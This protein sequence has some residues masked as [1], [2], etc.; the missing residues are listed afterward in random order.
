MNSRDATPVSRDPNG[1]VTV[2][3]IDDE[4]GIRDVFRDALT[5]FGYRVDATPSGFHALSMFA[6][7]RHRVVLTDL[8]MPE[9][10]GWEVIERLRGI[11]PKVAI[12][13]V[14][15]HALQTDIDRAHAEHIVL[16]QKPVMIRVLAQLIATVLGLDAP[17]TR[18][19]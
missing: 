9:M 18:P 5:M 8:A 17:P 16:V 14:T 11:D 2:L 19:G 3:V 6:G 1:D 4:D 7:T 15:G 13:I 10:S 12:I